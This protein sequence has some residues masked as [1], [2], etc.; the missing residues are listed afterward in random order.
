MVLSG[1]KV[2]SHSEANQIDILTVSVL[3]FTPNEFHGDAKCKK[4]HPS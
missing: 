3:L 2:S 1:S 4:C